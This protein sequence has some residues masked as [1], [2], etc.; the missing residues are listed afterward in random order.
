MCETRPQVPSSLAGLL[1]ASAFA[2]LPKDMH[3][4]VK[5]DALFHY[6]VRMADMRNAYLSLLEVSGGDASGM[7]SVKAFQAWL[8]SK[9][10]KMADIKTRYPKFAEKYAEMAARKFVFFL[11]TKRSGWIPLQKLVSS[12][13]FS[14]FQEEFDRQQ[15][16][17]E[18]RQ[19]SMPGPNGDPSKWFSPLT[20]LK[21]YGNFLK[22]DSKSKD[23]LTPEQFQLWGQGGLSSLFIEQLWQVTEMPRFGAKQTKLMDFT[24][25]LDFSLGICHRHTHCGL[26]YLWKVLDAENNALLSKFHVQRLIKSV[27]TRLREKGQEWRSGTEPIVNK[28][29]GLIKPRDPDKIDFR[30]LREAPKG[31]GYLAIEIMI[32]AVRFWQFNNPQQQALMSLVHATGSR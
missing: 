27:L 5:T 16:S 3:G 13:H 6:V 9:A 21:V 7:I 18:E 10:K 28:I 2:R 19:M 20:A 8:L 17:E 23:R 26:A 29:F 24:T 14:H 4:R 31:S 15:R 25:Y 30:D 12:D 11:D 22:L 1:N 32:D